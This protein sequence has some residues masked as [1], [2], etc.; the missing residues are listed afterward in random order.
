MAYDKKRKIDEQQYTTKKQR[1]I[2][3][4]VQLKTMMNN[5]I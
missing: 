2:N 5:I 1:L 3:N 4:I